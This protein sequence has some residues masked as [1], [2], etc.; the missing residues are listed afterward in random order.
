MAD[1]IRV[2][3]DDDAEALAELLSRN[4]A[5]LA[6][7]DPLRDE[8]Y[9]TVEGQRRLLDQAVRRHQSGVDWPG[10]ITVH[11]EPVGRVNLSNVIR[12]AFCS[13]DLGYWVDQAHN[14]RGVATAAVAA[15]LRVAFADLG[16]HRVQAGTLLQNRGSQKVLRRNGF[17]PI[18]VAPR[19]LRIAGRWQD[20]L[21]F[22]RLSDGPEP[23][24]TRAG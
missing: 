4:R 1:G 12:G 11:D 3:C 13:A 9:F 19:Y 22:Q 16:L 8:A 5:F 23:Q 6:P 24:R 7:W 14:G 20:H 17:Q 21:L 18:G 2:V 15:V 10:M